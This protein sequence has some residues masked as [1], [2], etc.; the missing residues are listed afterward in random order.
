MVLDQVLYDRKSQSKAGSAPRPGGILLPEAVEDVGEE[1]GLDP[2]A[3]VGH[4]DLDVRVHAL[5]QDLDPAIPPGE[6]D[7]VGQEVPHH[8]LQPVR[9]AVD[10]TRARI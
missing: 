3:S 9:V 8:L 4:R 1:L 2:D 10:R 6:L 7:C 5:Q